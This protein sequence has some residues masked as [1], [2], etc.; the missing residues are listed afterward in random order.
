MLCESCQK[1][2]ATVHL[3]EI[4][5]HN[6]QK[7]LHLCEECAQKQ[8]FPYKMQFSIAEVLG[9]LIEPLMGK[10]SKE[11]DQIKC[12]HCGITYADF[13]KKARFGCAEDYEVFKEGVSVLLEKIHGSA[14]HRGKMPTQV[15]REFLQEKEIKELQRE[16]ERMVQAEEF[17]QAVEIRD[18]IKKLKEQK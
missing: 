18:K 14:W 10:L 1:K 4:V 13:K 2:N 5:N 12:S 11:M 6:I 15:S 16:L 7:E 9:G 17:E 3:T 8:G